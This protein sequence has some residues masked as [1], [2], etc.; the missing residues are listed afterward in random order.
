[1]KNTFYQRLHGADINKTWVKQNLD[2]V[3]QQISKL[4]R[5]ASKWDPD[6][7]PQAQ[8]M[9]GLNITDVSLNV[10]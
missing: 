5:N 6:V 7:I 2:T 9:F 1:M 8:S 4:V 10:K 3:A